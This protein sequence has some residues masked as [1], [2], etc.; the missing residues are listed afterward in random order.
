MSIFYYIY[1]EGQ[2]MNNE[3]YQTKHYVEN[4]GNG[5]QQN[6]TNI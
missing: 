5:T 4:N 1:F 3:F 6:T 2:P